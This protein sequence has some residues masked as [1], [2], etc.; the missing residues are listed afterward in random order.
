MKRYIFR[1]YT[2]TE[3]EIMADTYAGAEDKIYTQDCVLLSEWLD[4]T[5]LR[6]VVIRKE[7]N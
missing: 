7:N 2:I 3:Y 4:K 5:T 6:R 1:E